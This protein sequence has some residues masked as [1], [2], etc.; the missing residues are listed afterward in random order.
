MTKKKKIILGIIIILIVTSPIIFIYGRK[1]YYGFKNEV[2][3]KAD[4]FATTAVTKKV[5]TTTDYNNLKDYMASK[6]YKVQMHIE[7][8][9]GGY[10]DYSSLNKNIS[11]KTLNI[12]TIIGTSKTNKTISVME[13]V[14]H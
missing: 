5:V 12:L 3:N 7:D 10:T 13:R 9:K 6:D 1:V 11:L 14:N 4:A 8:G 2:Y